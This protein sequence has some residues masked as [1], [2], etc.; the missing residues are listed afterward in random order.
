MYRIPKVIVTA[1]AV[2][3]SSPTY[4]SAHGHGCPGCGHTT[5]PPVG[6]EVKSKIPATFTCGKITY[7]VDATSDNPTTFY[8]GSYGTDYAD[9]KSGMVVSVITW[10][11][12]PKT[13]ATVI[14]VSGP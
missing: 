5:N 7:V 1:L 14:Y 12:S 13:A 6:C 11:K 8:L 3:L 4:V 2:A 10:T 9:L